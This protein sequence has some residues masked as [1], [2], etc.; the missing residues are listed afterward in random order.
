MSARYLALIMLEIEVEILAYLLAWCSCVAFFWIQN[1]VSE[2]SPSQTVDR[3]IQGQI[4]EKRQEIGTLNQTAQELNT[5]GA[6]QVAEPVML[7]MNTQWREIEQRFT[8]FRKPVREE[9]F[10]ERTVTELKT[11]YKFEEN[12]VQQESGQKPVADFGTLIEEANA[13]CVRVVEIQSKLKVPE[14]TGAAFENFS[15]QEDH[16]K[17]SDNGRR[18][19]VC[20]NIAG[21]PCVLW[22]QVEGVC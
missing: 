22:T 4:E 9:V 7:R 1:S 10:V 11:T 6:R 17:V 13:L 14:L 12:T 8:Q 3:A 5:D 18:I 20:V 21:S 19:E 2:T 15:V 16:V